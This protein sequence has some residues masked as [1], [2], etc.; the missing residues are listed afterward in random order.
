M[1]NLIKWSENLDLN[2]FYKEAHRRGYQNNS[3][4][5]AMIDCF[6]N[7]RE[8]SAWILYENN[9]AMGS[10][11]AHSFDDVTGPGTYRVLTRV[12]AFA[13]ARHSKGLGS[14]RTLI[15]QHQNVTDQFYLPTC[16]EWAKTKELY[17]TSTDNQVGSQR[18]VHRTYFPI[19]EKM[20]IVDR[21]G[22][23]Y[24]RNTN[25]TLW[26]INVDEFWKSINRYPR[27]TQ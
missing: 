10:V 24:Y 20:G 14:Y 21:V 4:Q 18:A 25:Q 27:W 17:T 16:I 6:C 3:S 8:W 2:E 9:I 19:L 12:C 15:K 23:I 1:Y 13:E 7:E 26:K 5:K 11:A 22:D